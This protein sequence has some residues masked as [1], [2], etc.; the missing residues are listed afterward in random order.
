MQNCQQISEQSTLC[1]RALKLIE[2]LCGL[3]PYYRESIKADFDNIV[4]IWGDT[5]K[6]LSDEQLRI[7]CKWLKNSGLKFCPEVPYFRFKCFGLIDSDKA[8][9]IAKTDHYANPAIY[10][11]ASKISS[12]H[13]KNLAE[14]DLRRKFMQHYALV[15]EA[16]MNGA[17]I[18][19]PDK[20]KLLEENS[21]VYKLPRKKTEYG[22]EQSKKLLEFTK[23]V[24]AKR[25][26]KY[27]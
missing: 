5:I 13:W 12:Y 17:Q 21:Q 25:R 3:F 15:C 20:S 22:K 16:V 8:F 7:G 11:A 23:T 1:N 18:N 2:Y 6:D 24:H 10:G 14:V 9:E 27:A 26:L 4:K 19:V